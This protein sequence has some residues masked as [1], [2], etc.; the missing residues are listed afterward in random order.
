MDLGAARRACSETYVRLDQ[1][2][3][4]VRTPYSFHVSGRS[5]LES[6]FQ[7]PGNPIS[8]Y[9]TSLPLPPWSPLTPVRP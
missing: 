1:V 9:G 3:K 5:K 7:R 2:P 6:I 8:G 4:S